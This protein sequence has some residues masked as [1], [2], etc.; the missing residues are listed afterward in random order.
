MSSTPGHP[1]PP[2]FPGLPLSSASDAGQAVP[3]NR[4]G[5]W[6]ARPDF[7]TDTTRCPSCFTAITA[8]SF[9][10]AAN[11]SS[12]P[13]CVSC[14]LD[15]SGPAAADVFDAGMSVVV[16]ESHRQQILGQ[17]RAS[18]AARDAALHAAAQQSYAPA[19][20]G[21]P[22]PL[23]AWYP[24][25]EAPPMNTA[26]SPAAQHP[27]RPRRSGVQILM[28]TVGVILVSIMAI[29]FVLL[30]YLIASLE[31][32]S[33]LTGVAS[34]AVFGV[35]WL[36]HRRR[37]A[38]TAQGIAVLAVVL[39]LL[40]LW[41]IRANDLFGSGGLDGWVYSGLATGVLAGLLTLGYRI[42]P[43]RSLSIATVLLAPFAVFAFTLGMFR[44]ADP[45]TS[46]WAA[47]TAVAAAA[48]VWPLV[49]FGSL[50]RG[51]IRAIGLLAAAFAIFPAS[52]AFPG[53]E[54]APV[55]SLLVLAIVWFGHLLVSPAALPLPAS[56]EVPPSAQPG[57][58]HPR[59]F[60]MQVLAAVGLGFT[61]AA[62]GPAVWFRLPELSMS[63]W[64]PAAITLGGGIVLALVARFLS[65]RRRLLQLSAAMPLAIG[66]LATAPAAI[67][68]LSQF[69]AIL[70]AP[71][72]SL[73]VVELL[74][75][76]LSEYRWTV[77]LALV[78]VTVLMASVLALIDRLST[79]GWI[80]AAFGA[81]GLIAAS[82]ALATPA[83]TSLGLIVVAIAGLLA[84]TSP[85]LAGRYR[86]VSAV[87]AAL[88]TLGLFLVGQ[89]STVTFPF[90]VLA[91]IA[92][93]VTFREVVRQVLLHSTARWLAPLV[94]VALVSVLILSA[95]LIPTW[96]QAVTGATAMPTGPALFLSLCA[97]AILAAVPLTRA[98]LTRPESAT[99]AAVS[100][101]PLGLGLAELSF[102][103]PVDAVPFLVVCGITAATGL[104][105]QLVRPV[106]N[107]PER[108]VAALATPPLVVLFVSVLSDQI[109]AAATPLVAAAAVVLL[110]GAA[111]LLF[112][113]ASATD[114]PGMPKRIARIGW[115]AALALSAAPPVVAAVADS[116]L[117]W[118]ALLLT[119]VAA[120]IVA[121]GEGGVFRGQSRR[122]HVA[123]VGLP[124]AIG[125]LWLA[126]ARNDVTGLEFYTL[127][128]AGLLLALLVLIL[129][130]RTDTTDGTGRTALFAA[131][132]A[133]ALLPSAAAAESSEPIRGAIVIGVASSLL[134]GGPFLA[135]SFRGTRTAAVVWLGGAAAA[136]LTVL[137]L[138]FRGDPAGWQN[139]AVAGALLLGGLLWLNRTQ[140]PR[141][142][143]TAAIALSPVL[144][145]VSV[146]I[147]MA[148]ADVAVWRFLL[149]LL[150][151]SALSAVTTLPRLRVPL[152][153]WAAVASA[154]LVAAVGVT[155]GVADPFE[156]ATVPVAVALLVGGALRMGA[157]PATR[158]WPSLGAGVLLLLIPSLLADFGS[159]ELWRV[160]ALGVV[161]LGVFGAG[162]TLKLSAPTLLGAG[163]LVV[164][165]LAQLWPWISG[166]YGAVPWWLWAGIGGVVLIFFAATYEKRIRDLRTAARSISSLR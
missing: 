1:S 71:P 49:R 84:T 151:I 9:T 158:S 19:P 47:L 38:G 98:F 165:G 143:G 5:I 159:T 59:T 153:R 80:P 7:L 157:D 25:Q 23:S 40:D 131:A 145:A 77:A 123:W 90:S 150:A 124:L 115:D 128:V 29:F 51:I 149:V 138:A 96:V 17:M 104:L 34:F 89:T 93:L 10:P 20:T 48:L 6:P 64:A 91:T 69:G 132:V 86:L 67:V 144:L 88:S 122:R 107:W 26:G 55:L 161:A 125:A 166:L 160:L 60:V 100:V 129:I 95:R 78:L 3:E 97:L 142:F 65:A 164:H 119:A 8:S 118:V 62:I 68:A 74:P 120:L 31:V 22:T 152:V 16:A 53:P 141:A 114:T 154:V 163:V 92:L 139:E 137:V 113:P 57:A 101:I 108:Y 112:R 21:Y 33:V 126:L 39:L 155:T 162:L 156:L 30:A 28:L 15:L 54:A 105:W 133:V 35:A 61:V 116:D 76:V 37:L 18:Q 24:P 87:G 81:L 134:V 41:I 2:A 146:S 46:S 103:I 63:L 135:R 42:L 102:R 148:S 130:R 14:G 109:D 11:G 72:L 82:F 83:L 44:T 85:R 58:A 36:L 79:E 27:A 56:V 13:V 66:A 111:L 43:L 52:F 4:P 12:G 70:P 110:A 32:R 121:S 45:T 147:A 75:G 117:G 99:V 140:V 73:T 127:P 50:E 94:L 136:V 106:A